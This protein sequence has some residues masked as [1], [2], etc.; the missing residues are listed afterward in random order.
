MLMADQS[1]VDLD[2]LMKSDHSPKGNM[3]DVS[4][5]FLGSNQSV[6]KQLQN[7]STSADNQT[8]SKTERVLKSGAT[9]NAKVL[10]TWLNETLGDE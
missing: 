1:S 3:G 4:Q 9:M 8:A 6:E 2:E 7:R 10:E 5:V